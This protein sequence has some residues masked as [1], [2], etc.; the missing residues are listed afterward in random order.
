MAICKS[1]LAKRPLLYT[2][3]IGGEQ[4]CRD[5]IWAVTTEELN[6][7]N[8]R[9]RELEA[10]LITARR[11]INEYAGYFAA[12]RE[13]LLAEQA[14]SDKLEDALKDALARPVTSALCPGIGRPSTRILS[15]TR[16]TVFTALLYSSIRPTTS[17]STHGSE[18]SL[19]CPH[20][21]SLRT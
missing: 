7:A 15:R 13:A 20:P 14:L 18:N 8:E 1:D 9:I 11:T 17:Q 21:I 12:E 2:D 5:D 10:E 6:A 19:P 16:I 3:S 4:V